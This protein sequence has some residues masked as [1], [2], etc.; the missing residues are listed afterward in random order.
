MRWCAGG[1]ADSPQ[2]LTVGAQLLVVELELLVV[3]AQLRRLVPRGRGRRPGRLGLLLRLPN[4]EDETATFDRATTHAC[5]S[6][7]T[8]AHTQRAHAGGTH[9]RPRTRAARTRPRTRTCAAYACA[10]A[11]SW[12]ELARR[13]ETA[14]R[15]CWYS[16]ASWLHCCN[17]VSLADC[18]VCAYD[19]IS[20]SCAA[21]SAC[22]VSLDCASLSID[23]SIE[24]WTRRRQM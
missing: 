4:G 5:R 16:S 12:E 18:S 3:R 22:V 23:H 6:G 7:A 19:A 13:A 24:S 21:R 8:G 20:S 9:A 15:R 1:G 11:A 2:L 14:C 17:S 10:C